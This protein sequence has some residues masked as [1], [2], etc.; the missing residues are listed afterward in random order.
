MCTT[1]VICLQTDRKACFHVP[2]RGTGNRLLLL[3]ERSGLRPA[4][5]THQL[6]RIAAQLLFAG[7]LDAALFDGRLYHRR[8]G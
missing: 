8:E 4:A 5:L 6:F 3:W 7:K 1:P 2:D